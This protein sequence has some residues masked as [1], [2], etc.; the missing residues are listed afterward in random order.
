M[1]HESKRAEQAKSQQLTRNSSFTP[2]I[3]NYGST[4]KGSK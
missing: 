2:V 4:D 3:G 1:P